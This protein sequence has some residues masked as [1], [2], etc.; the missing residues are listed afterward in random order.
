MELIDKGVLVAEID[1]RIEQ[2]TDASFDSM[3]G[4]NLIEIKD[5]LD[6]IEVKEANNIWYDAKKTVPEDSTKQIICVKEDGLAI[7]TVGKI[8]NGTV[9]WTYLNNLLKLPSNIEVKEIDFGTEVY[10]YIDE[11]FN[12]YDD[13]NQTLQIKDKKSLC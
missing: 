3:I 12:V 7:V 8:A 9:K 4:K 6:T 11:H 1:K 10:K 5:F 2:L 13:R